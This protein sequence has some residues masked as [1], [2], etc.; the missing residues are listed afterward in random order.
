LRHGAAREASAKMFNLTAKSN[1]QLHASLRVPKYGAV[2]Q[3]RDRQLC[4]GK[5]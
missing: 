4:V 1:T 2:S 3:R 5:I